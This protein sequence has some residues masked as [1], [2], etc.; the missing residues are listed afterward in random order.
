LGDSLPKRHHYHHH[1]GQLRFAWE[2]NEKGWRDRG[3]GGIY[4]D[5]CYAQSRILTREIE[6]D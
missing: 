3:A 5:D 6:I 1:H 4:F 2:M